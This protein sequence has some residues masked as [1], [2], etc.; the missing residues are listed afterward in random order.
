MAKAIDACVAAEVAWSELAPAERF[1]ALQQQA[2]HEVQKYWKRLRKRELQF[3]YFAAFEEDQSGKP[4]MHCLLHEADPARPMRKRELDES[5]SLGFSNFRLLSVGSDG[6]LPYGAIAYVTKSLT[7]RG[8]SRLCASFDY[9]P[10][11]L[12]PKAER[13][14]Q[15]MPLGL[16]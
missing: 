13:P 1:V 2:L 15:M 14:R 6:R 16:A 5:W 11:P 3:K 12:L 10:E 9:R 7:K 8:S 4:H